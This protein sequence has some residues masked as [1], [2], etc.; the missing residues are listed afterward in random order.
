MRTFARCIVP[1]ESLCGVLE[2]STSGVL[3]FSFP[4]GFRVMIYHHDD[5]AEWDGGAWGPKQ[6]L[7]ETDGHCPQG[8]SAPRFRTSINGQNSQPVSLI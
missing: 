1:E 3:G 2:C 7:D 5:V 4:Q 8:T 6:C